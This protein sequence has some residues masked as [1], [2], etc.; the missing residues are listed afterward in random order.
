MLV[1]ENNAINEIENL[2]YLYLGRVLSGRISKHFR[3]EECPL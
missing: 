3:H 1:L 2:C